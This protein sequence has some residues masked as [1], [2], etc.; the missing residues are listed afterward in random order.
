MGPERAGKALPA[1]GRGS[2][3]LA[4]AVGPEES[5]DVVESR[6]TGSG[7]GQDPGQVGDGSSEIELGDGLVTP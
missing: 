6:G 2:W 5:R 3:D 1:C 4:A 7:G